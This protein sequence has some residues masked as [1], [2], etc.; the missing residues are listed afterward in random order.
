MKRIKFGTRGPTV[1][2]CKVLLMPDS[3]SLVWGHLVH[4]AKFPSLQFLKLC[5]SPNFR[6]IHP[7]FIQGIIITQAVT[8]YGDL[9]KIAKIMAL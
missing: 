3:L 7:N 9:P 8:F 6:P 1:H 4:F 2:I 5:S